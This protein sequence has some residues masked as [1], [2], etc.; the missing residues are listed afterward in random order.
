MFVSPFSKKMSNLSISLKK[1]RKSSRKKIMRDAVLG[2][3]KNDRETRK[4][5]NSCHLRGWIIQVCF[6][7]HAIFYHNTKIKDHNI[8]VIETIL[9][10]KTLQNYSDFFSV[11]WVNPKKWRWSSPPPCL[12]KI[13]RKVWSFS[14]SSYLCVIQKLL[15]WFSWP[16]CFHWR[17]EI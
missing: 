2:F 4:G 1:F 6:L 13:F 9:R 17:V 14:S 3:K 16:F 7:L 8:H 12:S 5:G 15:R 10:T 11:T